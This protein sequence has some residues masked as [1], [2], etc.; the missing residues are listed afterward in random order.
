MEISLLV[1]SGHAAHIA[2]RQVLGCK[3]LGRVN[4]HFAG[5]GQPFGLAELAIS[6]M[7]RRFHRIVK[8]RSQ[9]C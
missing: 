9:T 2:G 5:L 4:G 8:M 6:R 3:G 1:R 7:T